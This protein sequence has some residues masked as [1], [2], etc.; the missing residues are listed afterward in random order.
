MLI[1]LNIS[2]NGFDFDEVDE[3]DRSMK[4]GFEVRMA[5]IYKQVKE[6]GEL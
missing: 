3:K 2:S 1:Y 5:E 4:D 6:S